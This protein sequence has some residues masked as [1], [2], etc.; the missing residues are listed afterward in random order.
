MDTIDLNQLDDVDREVPDTPHVEIMFDA[1]NDTLTGT[2]G[3][4]LTEAQHYANGVLFANS[5]RVSGNE[6]FFGSIASGVKSAYDYIVKMFKSIW[7][8]FFNR[9]AAEEAK[10]AKQEVAA[11]KAEVQKAP[12][13]EPKKLEDHQAKY[14]KAVGDVISLAGKFEEMM[15]HVNRRPAGEA[16][17]RPGP[18][19]KGIA[20][21]NIIAAGTRAYEPTRVLTTKNTTRFDDVK[22]K[23]DAAAVFTALEHDIGAGTTL[24]NT[25][26]TCGADI[27]AEIKRLEKAMTSGPLTT[28]E[29]EELRVLRTVMGMGTKI[30]QYLK[31]LVKAQK[32]LATVTGEMF[33]A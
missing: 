27:G 30:A 31:R 28:E 26:K 11:Q 2:E 18:N 7:G 13:P 1:L 22:S 9:D 29:N 23:A 33:K 25:L 20:I 32:H 21:M 6:S 3:M 4:V 8:F 17:L 19:S 24:V 10:E 14:K 5:S 16:K 15:E 12:E